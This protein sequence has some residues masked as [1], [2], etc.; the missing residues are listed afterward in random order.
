MH[1]VDFVELQLK[2]KDNFKQVFDIIL[3]NN[4]KS[5]MQK[6]IL[7][8]PGDW[9]SQF[10]SRQIVY[11]HVTNYIRQQ[12]NMATGND[13][14]NNDQHP[15]LF[16]QPLP[17]TTTSPVPPM[18]SVVPIIGPLHVSINSKEHVLLSFNPFFQNVY[19][20][21]FKRF[22]F[23]KKPKPWCISLLLEIIYGGRPL[24]R[25]L[26][27]RHLTNAKTFNMAHF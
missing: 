19:Q 7:L 3:K 10:Y 24:F 22:K 17:S 6:Y 20:H 9:P 25:L 15:L 26:Q 23:P 8:Q 1:L 12:Q 2:S 5:Y 27:E 14:S 4:I 18:A 16:H 21:L 13:N 11:E